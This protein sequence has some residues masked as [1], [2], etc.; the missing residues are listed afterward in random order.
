M[1]Y[2][3][4]SRSPRSRET[5]RERESKGSRGNSDKNNRYLDL[6]ISPLVNEEV[7]PPVNIVPTYGPL[8]PPPPPP[9]HPQQYQV[10]PPYGLPYPPSYFAQYYHQ[11]AISTSGVIDKAESSSRETEIG[12]IEPIPRQ[13]AITT[14]GRI[15]LTFKNQVVTL[16][17]EIKQTC[18]IKLVG[19]TNHIFTYKAVQSYKKYLKRQ[20]LPTPNPKVL[21]ALAIIRERDKLNELA[22]KKYLAFYKHIFKLAA[23]KPLSLQS[24]IKRHIPDTQRYLTPQFNHFCLEPPKEKEPIIL[25]SSQAATT[26]GSVKVNSELLRA[27]KK[28]HDNAEQQ[29]FH[30]KALKE[31]AENSKNSARSI[32]KFLSGGK[33]IE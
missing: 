7:Q 16:L 6:N 27:V 9:P 1:S 31:L 17:H 19:P 25:V 8:P 15:C 26:S 30:H 22:Y 11:Q 12:R 5:T 13:I 3:N 20:Q 18:V 21:E 29:E 33:D 4:R 10:Y 2:R 32:Y 28:L 14:K 23:R 24:R